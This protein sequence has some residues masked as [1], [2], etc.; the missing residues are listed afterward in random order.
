MREEKRKRLEFFFARLGDKWMDRSILFWL[1]L[2]Q[3]RVGLEVCGQGSRFWGLEL[4][5]TSFGGCKPKS[6]N[7]CEVFA[8]VHCP[9]CTREYRA[10][11]YYRP[12]LL[13]ATV[14]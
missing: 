11:C 13:A 1:L 14:L 9:N 10:T 2:Q 12:A 3:S 6:R 5:R 8:L 7:L 4:A